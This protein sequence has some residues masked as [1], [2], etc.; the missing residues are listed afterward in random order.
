MPI[1]A[2][3]RPSIS[4]GSRPTHA[5][6][7]ARRERARRLLLTFRPEAATEN[8]CASRCDR[9]R[10]RRRQHSLRAGRTRLVGRRFAGAPRTHFRI[11]LARR[12]PDVGLRDGLHFEPALPAQPRGLCEGRGRDGPAGRFSPLRHAA[13]RQHQGSPGRVPALHR[14]RR[15]ARRASPHRRASGGQETLAAHRVHRRSRR[16]ALSPARRPR[17]SRRRDAGF[18]QGRARPRRGNPA[19]NRSGRHRAD[20]GRGMAHHDRRR[21][22]RLRACRDRDGK[23]RTP[24]G[25]DGR[26]RPSR[27][28]HRASVSGH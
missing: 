18:G 1:A 19:P 14:H 15:H 17:R 23:F 11:D 6:R 13:A 22:R 26:T 20:T 28:P 3:Y 7:R 10:R 16:R 24:N 2:T 4:P 9:R 5:Q 25:R 12:R 8:A 27:H 21:R